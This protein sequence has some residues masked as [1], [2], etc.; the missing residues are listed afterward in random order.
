MGEVAV[1]LMWSQ[2]STGVPGAH[3][4]RSPPQPFV[5]TTA[6]QPAAAAVRMPCTT[7]RTPRPS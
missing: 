4:S 2:I 1:R 7:A 5:M 6:R 3:D